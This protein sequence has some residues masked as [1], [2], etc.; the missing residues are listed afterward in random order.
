MVAQL[1]VNQLVIGSNPIISAQRKISS[2]GLEHCFYTAEVKGSN[3]L[4][5]TNG[6]QSGTRLSETG[7][8]GDNKIGIWEY[9]IAAIAVDCKSTLF[10]VQRFE[11][12]YSH[13]LVMKLT[14]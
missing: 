3:P 12:S 1:T 13:K 2:V 8:Y 6:Y 10:R 5:S 4:F 11:S 9:R 14:R 7:G